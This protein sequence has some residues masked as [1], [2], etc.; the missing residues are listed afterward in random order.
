MSWV[1]GIVNAF[2]ALVTMML[3]GNA[4]SVSQTPDGGLT[5]DALRRGGYVIFIRHATA[6]QDHPLPRLMAV[7]LSHLSESTL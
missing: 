4:A 6:D 7:K 3:A 1:A 2:V 5:A